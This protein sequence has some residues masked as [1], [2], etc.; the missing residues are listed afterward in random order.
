MQTFAAVA[1]LG[2]SF[3]SFAASAHTAA[4]EAACRPDVFRLCANAIPDQNRIVACLVQN[5]RYLSQPCYQVFDREPNGRPVSPTRSPYP[6]QWG[7]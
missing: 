1:L 5:K 7:R 4:D 2:M 6:H 3:V